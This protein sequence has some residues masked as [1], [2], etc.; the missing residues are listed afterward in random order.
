MNYQLSRRYFLKSSAAVALSQLLGGCARGNAVSQILFLQ[1]SIPRQL[2]N[3]FRKSLDIDGKVEFKP[4]SHI[5]QIFDSLY[6][7]QQDKDLD[8][9]IREAINKI[10]DKILNRSQIS[11][12]LVTLGDAWLSTAIARNLIE[13]LP[14]QSLSNWGNLPESWQKLVQRDDEGYL[15]E[16]G[17]VYGAPYRWGSTV[18]AYRSDKLEPLNLT[19]KDWQD[20]WQPKLRDRLSLLDS[21]REIIGL[22]LKKLGQSYNTANLDS[23]ADLKTEL[24][25]LQQQ[26]KLYSSDRYL[27]PLILGDTW[28]AVAWSTDILPLQKR[29]PDIKFIIPQSGTSRWAD[30]WVQPKLP[31]AI[32]VPN[33]SKPNAVYSWI[34]YC[35]Q[36]ETAEKISQ[37]TDGV[38][39]ILEAVKLQSLSQPLQ[40]NTFINSEILNSDKSEFL[41]PLKPE[42][43]RQYRDLWIELRQ[44]NQ[45]K[46]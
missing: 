11:P 3:S 28:V 18:I 24:L 25:A 35:W 27:E 7:L 46:K 14:T 41:L 43:E 30:L 36:L 23:V 45:S 19:M 10:I 2:I 4:Q 29:Y 44:S 5:P 38:S 12:S 34:D 6:T 20:L 32:S 1:N 21:P 31:E 40:D 33:D 26:T 8:R 22:T 15:A 9:G 17:N 13:P 42:T 39:P 16:N 37:F